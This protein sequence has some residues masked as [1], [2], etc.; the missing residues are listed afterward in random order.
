LKTSTRIVRRGAIR[1]GWKIGG[2]ICVVGAG[3]AGTSAALEAAALGRKVILV[4]SMPA[5]GGQAVNS[6]IGTF[7]GLFS[8]GP[9]RFRLTH[10]IADGI[11][12]DLGAKG[13]LHYKDGPMTT[14]VLYDEVALSRWI[15][16]RI[17]DAGITV[18]LGAV[19]RD[20]VREGRRLCELD[21][22][23][24]YGDVRVTANGFVDASGD[25]A[26]TW[27]AGLEC[28][29]PI[30]PILGTQMVVL[31]NL[32]ETDIPTPAAF[33]ER[34][35]ARAHAYGLKRKDGLVFHFRG[36]NIGIVNMT[37][38][39]TP[40]E[41][42]AASRSGLIGR[43]QADSAF[44][45][46]RGEYPEIYRNAR[47]RGYGLPGIRQTRWIVGSHQLSTDEVISGTKFPDAIARTSWPIE[48]HNRPDGYEWK[49]FG[50]DH[51]HTV[52]LGS[53][54]ARDADNLVA[55]G[56]CIDADAAALSSVRVMGPC[57][58]MGAAAAHA[59]D[60]ADGGNVCEIDRAMLRERLYDNVDRID[61]PHLKC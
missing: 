30:T 41:P 53:L 15:E 58:A 47:I 36:R 2:D 44:Q 38:V 12:H 61:P 1:T 32:D 60:L 23:T 5:L 48:L 59:L 40:L 18:V 35:E 33:R 24:R 6:I 26:L 50:D 42:M 17:L 37:H 51:L 7:C 3:I 20:V 52:P 57:I 25:A 27:F 10:G 21:V 31:E 43:D 45:F 4:D 9:E 54:L 28:Q 13:A 49:P 19:L 39:E 22:A 16:Q 56:R 11:L 14:V 29:E 46:L 34:V 8:N 55:V